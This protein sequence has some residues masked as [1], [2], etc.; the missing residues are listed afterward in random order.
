MNSRMN[1]KKIVKSMFTLR[2]ACT[3]GVFA[4]SVALTPAAFAE[5]AYVAS[6]G[7]QAI[8]TGYR[9]NSKTK[10]EIDFKLDALNKGTEVF[11]AS[12]SAGTTCC[13][14][15]NNNGNLE[16]NFGGWCGGI[17]GPAKAER[18]TVVF[19]MPGKKVKIYA[20]GGTEPFN[21]KGSDK[22]NDAGALR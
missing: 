13:L 21:T 18:R 20:H 1:I 7:A 19:D 17:E 12:G 14:W 16:P 4:A 8:N 11:G 6:T 10:M 9:V 2:S 15:I 5:D 3:A 22:V